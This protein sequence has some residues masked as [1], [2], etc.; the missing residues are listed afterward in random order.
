MT[1]EPVGF[2]GSTSYKFLKYILGF[3]LVLIDNDYPFF[4]DKSKPPTLLMIFLIIVN[5]SIQSFL[6]VMLK[7]YI[8]G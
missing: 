6:I 2:I 4:L 1:D 3:P 8:R 7:K 5:I